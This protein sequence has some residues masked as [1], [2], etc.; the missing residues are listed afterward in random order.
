MM[1]DLRR[2][3]L[4]VAHERG[5][6]HVPSG[7]VEPAREGPQD[8]K[9]GR[10]FEIKHEAALLGLIIL[11]EADLFQRLQHLAAAIVDAMRLSNKCD[12]HVAVRGFVEQHLGMAGGDHLRTCAARGLGDQRIDLALAEN[13]EMGVGFVEQQCRAG[14]A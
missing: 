10:T 11:I 14:L 12:D 6:K 3:I 5:F 1:R 4:H 9:I 7:V 8:R 13:F 2:L